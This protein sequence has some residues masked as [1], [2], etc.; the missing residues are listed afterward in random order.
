M[1]EGSKQNA[2]VAN[3]RADLGDGL[4]LFHINQR[5]WQAN[6]QLTSTLT[7]CLYE[8]IYFVYTTRVLYDTILTTHYQ[9]SSLSL[10]MVNHPLSSVK[11]FNHHYITV[12]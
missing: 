1:A 6:Y 12:N 11:D 5:V 7:G 3:G 8:Q 4:S 10:Q 2:W 9:Y